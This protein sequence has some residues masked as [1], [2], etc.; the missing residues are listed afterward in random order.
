MS[1]SQIGKELIDPFGRRVEYVRLSVTDKCNM[2]CFYCIPKGFTDFEEPDNWL[3]FDEV[4]RLMGI[5][6]DL[7][8]KR[9]RLTGGEP[10]VRRNLPELATRL[11]A[12]PGIEDLSLSTNASLLSE[13]APALKDAGVSRIN[14]SLDS[15]QPERFKEITGGTLQ[16]VLDGLQAAKR[17]GLSP[18]KINVVAMKGLNDDEFESI[19]D[20]CLENDFTLRFIETM[21]VGSTGKDATDYYYDLQQL[22]KRLQK[23]FNLIPGMMP[24][25]GPARY[26]QIEGTELRIGFI[27]PISQHFCETCNRVRVSVDGTL[28]LCLGQNDKIELRPLLRDGSTDDQIRETI[29]AALA[30][31]PMRHEFKDEPGQVVRIMSQTGG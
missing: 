17:A 2:R 26:F 22:K 15:L 14:V 7:G 20:Y 5:F 9:L 11:S 4:E 19:V 30:L 8:V 3:T 16:T 29:V 12:I 1:D 23:R 18:V 28:Y 25:G 13:H 21:P 10:L 6:A 24:G 31:K 27:T